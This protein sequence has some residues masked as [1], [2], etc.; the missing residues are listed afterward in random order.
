LIQNALLAS[1]AEVEKQSEMDARVSTWKER[2]EEALEEQVCC[3]LE[4]LTILH[5]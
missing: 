5:L 1:I 2:I 4:L 3:W